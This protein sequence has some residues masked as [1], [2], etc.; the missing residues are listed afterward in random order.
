MSSDLLRLHR[1]TENGA[2]VVAASGDVDML[3]V[4]DLEQYLEAACGQ[5]GSDQTVVVD[6]SEVTFLGSSGL[7][8]LVQADQRC[9]QVGVTLRVVAANRVV[10]RALE[11]AGLQGVLDIASTVADAVT[12]EQRR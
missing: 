10:T 3:T 6:L 8:A 2:L 5:A 11:A 7:A 1:R 12:P 4:P 9:R